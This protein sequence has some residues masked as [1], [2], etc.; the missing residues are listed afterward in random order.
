MEGIGPLG[1]KVEMGFKTKRDSHFSG[2][3]RENSHRKT[4]Q[5]SDSERP[6]AGCGVG[7]QGLGKHILQENKDL[8]KGTKAGLLWE[9]ITLITNP[10]LI[11]ESV[12]GPCD[13]VPDKRLPDGRT[14]AHW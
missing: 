13:L 14:D 8:P 9:I 11:C 5:A 6:T 1:T 7:S 12:P 2:S 4:K 10:C 3:M